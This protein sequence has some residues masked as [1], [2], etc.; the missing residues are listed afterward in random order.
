MPPSQPIRRGYGSPC[1]A[2]YRQSLS[3]RRSLLRSPRRGGTATTTPRPASP[4]TALL[5]PH[6]TSARNSRSCAEP[7]TTAV[8]E[9]GHNDSGRP[10]SRSKD[11]SAASP[12]P[13]SSCPTSRSNSNSSIRRFPPRSAHGHSPSVD[14]GRPTQPPNVRVVHPDTLPHTGHSGTHHQISASSPAPYTSHTA[15]SSNSPTQSFGVGR[16]PLPQGIDLPRSPERL[17][18]SHPVRKRRQADPFAAVAQSAAYP[19]RLNRQCAQRP[20]HT[21]EVCSTTARRRCDTNACRA[22]CTRRPRAVRA[23]L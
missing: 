22:D 13:P 21:L 12:I 23:C 14:I 6:R 18:P 7:A 2:G 1:L 20:P 4:T 17:K 5:R 16:P 19:R 11:N 10:G 3:L 8:A 9:P 15:R